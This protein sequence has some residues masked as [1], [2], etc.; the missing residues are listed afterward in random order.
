MQG[1][2]AAGHVCTVMGWT[3]YE[4][5]ARRYRVPIVVT[6]FEPLDIL[7][8]IDL[9]VR[10]LEE[11]RHE[12]EN[13]YVRA[14]RREGTC[15]HATWSAGCSGWWIANGA[16]SVRSP[17]SGLGLREEFADF[18]AEYRFGLGAL[19]VKEPAECRAGEV[20]RG[21]AQ[22]A[23]VS[24]LRDPLHARA[25]A[26]RADG[27]LGGCLRGLLQLRPAPRCRPAMTGGMTVPSA[28]DA[29]VPG[30]AAGAGSG[31]AGSRLRRQAER[32][33]AARAL[34]A[35]AGQSG[36]LASWATRPWCRS[37]AGEIAISTDTFVVSPLEF[38]GGNIGSLAVHGTLNDL[39]MMGARPLYLCGRVRAGGGLGVRG[40]R[41]GRHCHGGDARRL[42]GVPLVAG[43]TK[44]VE[45]GKADGLYINTTGVG[46]LDPDF[47]PAPASC[48][49]P[50]TSCWSADR[51]AGMAWPSWPLGKD[52][53]SR[54][55]FTATPPV[56]CR[57][58]S[59]CAS[60]SVR[61]CT[62]CAIRPGEDWPAL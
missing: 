17:P 3:E 1:F 39:A 33:P 20:L 56:W 32:G 12:V 4:P 46:V 30:A 18:D 40:A 34:P 21:S 50:G 9:A 22:T 43:D 58:S 36:T 19:Q 48:A 44:V 26:R 14:V 27:V 41:P 6:G 57:W 5:I 45:R 29:G 23:P 59:A 54:P 60:A 62:P 8:G 28:P 49:V 25:P 7:E 16:G 51:S 38:P 10:Q 35:A 31:P 15:R 53:P 2:L 61:R 37:D 55:R 13:Q 47:R 11:G 42:A 52:W 24:R